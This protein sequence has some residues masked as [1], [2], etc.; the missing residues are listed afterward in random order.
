MEADA[1][2]AQLPSDAHRALYDTQDPQ[3][4]RRLQNAA[5]GITGYAVYSNFRKG[6]WKPSIDCRRRIS[7]FVRSM[8]WPAAT[9]T[10]SA[11]LFERYGELF[12]TLQCGDHKT[13]VAL[14]RFEP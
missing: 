14:A 4:F 8:N 3:Q 1:H 2:L 9:E 5:G 11:E 13:E 6:D 10:L 12:V 7:D